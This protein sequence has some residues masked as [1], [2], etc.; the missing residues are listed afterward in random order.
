M[1]KKR[2]RPFQFC[3]GYFLWREVAKGLHDHGEY[4]QH[5]PLQLFIEFVN[6]NLNFVNEKKQFNSTERKS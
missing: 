1:I 3:N 4:H 2:N 5:Q 6:S